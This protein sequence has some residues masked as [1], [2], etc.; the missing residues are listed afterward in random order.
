MTK[1]GRSRAAE[2]F[3]QSS[4]VSA[5]RH[6]EKTCPAKLAGENGRSNSFV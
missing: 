2:L 1:L 6:V 4:H 3:G 5:G